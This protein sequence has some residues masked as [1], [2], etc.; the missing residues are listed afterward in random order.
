MIAQ[1]NRERHAYKIMNIRVA[2]N[3]LV[4]RKGAGAA[5]KSMLQT[6]T[7]ETRRNSLNPCY[8]PYVLVY[9]EVN[10]DP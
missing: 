4:A 10:S 7:G 3:T 1:A 8:T 2:G 5:A 6:C 9:H